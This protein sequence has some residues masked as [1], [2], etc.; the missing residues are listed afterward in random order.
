MIGS[1]L[2]ARNRVQQQQS[3]MQCSR[4]QSGL[5]F[6]PAIVLRLLSLGLRT[7]SGPY[8]PLPTS[9]HTLPAGTAPNSTPSSTF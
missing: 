6:I 3:A 5:L 9:T 7:Q 1:A 2:N 4:V 8:P